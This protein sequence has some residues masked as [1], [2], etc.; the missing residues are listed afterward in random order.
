MDVITNL[1][2]CDTIIWLQIFFF[3]WSNLT[4]KKFPNLTK[5][6]SESINSFEAVA[7]YL[8]PT[9]EGL[10]VS[11][12]SWSHWVRGENGSPSPQE[13]KDNLTYQHSYKRLQHFIKDLVRDER[14]RMSFSSW[15]KRSPS[16][17]KTSHLIW[18]LHKKLKFI[19]K[20]QESRLIS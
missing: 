12:I 17:R 13:G 6:D 3:F 2:S 1:P 18:W 16:G 8:L 5:L 14:D 10:K 20:K 19:V 15:G 4:F 7:R 11:V 9:I